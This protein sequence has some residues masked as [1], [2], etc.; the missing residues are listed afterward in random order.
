MKKP[1]LFLVFLIVVLSFVL[2]VRYG[3]QVEKTNKF[4]DYL[5]SLSPTK[6]SSPTPTPWIIENYRSKKWGLR[7]YFPS[8]LSV[9]ED[10]TS[11]AVYIELKK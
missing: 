6:P 5:T 8:F 4:I 7:F 3:Q 11:P 10:P 9:K 2:G 1:Y